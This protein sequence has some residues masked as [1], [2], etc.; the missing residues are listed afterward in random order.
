VEF[1]QSVVPDYADVWDAIE[2]LAAIN[3]GRS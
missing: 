1:S 2:T 3:E